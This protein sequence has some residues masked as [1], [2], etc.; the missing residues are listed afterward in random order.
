MLQFYK[1]TVISYIN[2]TTA[3]T[4]DGEIAKED[5]D[6]VILNAIRSIRSI[7]LLII[8]EYLS[9]SLPNS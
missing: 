1:I 2:D 5:L 7:K 8:Y 3:E 4:I 6:N 9:D